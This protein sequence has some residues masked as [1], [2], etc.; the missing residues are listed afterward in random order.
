LAVLIDKLR[1]AQL[2]SRLAGTYNL[3]LG[4][5]VLVEGVRHDPDH[6]VR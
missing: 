5:V 1:D 6:R 4:Q 3:A 2:L